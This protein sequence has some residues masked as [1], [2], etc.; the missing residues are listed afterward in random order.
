MLY[1]M[2]MHALE[3][4]VRGGER[5]DFI[6]RGLLVLYRDEQCFVAGAVA[7]DVGERHGGYLYLSGGCAPLVEG[8]ERRG[9]AKVGCRDLLLDGHFI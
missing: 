9:T 4:G 6:V 3:V 1:E 2:V 7:G 5:L 8:R